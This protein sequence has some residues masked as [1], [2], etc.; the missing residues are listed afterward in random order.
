M[1]IKGVSYVEYEKLLKRTIKTLKSFLP[2]I[3]RSNNAN[4]KDAIE[5]AKEAVAKEM[6]HIKLFED[7]KNESVNEQYR[8]Y[9]RDRIASITK[10][11]IRV[12]NEIGLVF[13]EDSIKKPLFDLIDSLGEES[14]FELLQNFKYGDSNFILFG[15]NGSGKT[16]LIKELHSKMFNTN[17]IVI[18]AI[19]N[20]DYSSDNA[21]F[22]NKDFVFENIIAKTEEKQALFFLAKLALQIEVK[23]RRQNEQEDF[24]VTNKIKKIFHSLGLEREL[25]IGENGD[26]ELSPQE[27]DNYSLSSASDGEKSAL[28]FIMVVLLAPQKSFLI[29]DEPENHLNGSLMKKLFDILENERRDIKFVYATHNISFIESRT[30]AEI[31]YLRKTKG[32]K[33]WEYNAFDCFGKLTSDLILNVEGTNDD[34]LFCEGEDGNSFDSKLFHLLYPS[35]QIIPS[36]GCEKVISRTTT[37]NEYQS[38][39]RKKSIGIVDFDF[40][41]ENMIERLKREGVYVLKVNEIENAFVLVDCLGKVIKYLGVKE[42]VSEV[43]SKIIENIKKK[44]KAVKADCATK[45]LR[46]IHQANKL[47]DVDRLEESLDLMNKSN[48]ECFKTS[49]DSFVSSLEIAVDSCDYDALMKLVPGKMIIN[50]CAELLGMANKEHYVRLVLKLIEGDEDLRSSLKNKLCDLN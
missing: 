4:L 41:D 32:K 11:C 18:P 35:Y 1:D 15:K 29:V 42:S 19:R 2:R 47:N 3:R 46:V 13:G 38:V 16:T 26:L 8:K 22:G 24:I 5:C 23:Q 48:N 50:N 10:R 17:S 44:I 27:G 20:I 12:N 45:L 36:N 7:E 25:V 43:K 6:G 37:F 33:K 14:T 28:Y 30:D 34:V 40:K 31:I 39:L 49:F 9:V 21:S